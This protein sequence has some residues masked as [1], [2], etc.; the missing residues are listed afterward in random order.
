MKDIRTSLVAFYVL[1]PLLTVARI[2]QQFL[3]IDAETGFY[4]AEG[5]FI[6]KIISW[7]FLGA[8]VIILLLAFLTPKICFAAPKKSTPLGI[9]SFALAAALFFDSAKVL[10]NIG[11]GKLNLVVAILGALSAVNF[12]MYGLTTLRKLNFRPFWRFSPCFG[13]R[14]TLLRSL[15]DI[16]AKARLLTTPFRPLLCALCFTPCLPIQKLLSARL[17]ASLPLL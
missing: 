17:A 16:P 4:T 6:A 8:F 14:L 12:V 9:V 15:C 1:T 2:L 11:G 7:T 5:E 10:M 13:Q 3:L